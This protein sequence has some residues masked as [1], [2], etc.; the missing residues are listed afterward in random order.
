MTPGKIKLIYFLHG[1]MA[2]D[3][4]ERRREI[5]NKALSREEREENYVEF[6]PKANRKKTELKSIL[7]DLISEMGTVSF[8]PDSK[9]VAVVYNLDELYMKKRKGKAKKSSGKKKGKKESREAFFIRYLEEDL[10]QTGN[11]LI[12]V[13]NENLE[14]NDRINKKSRL[15]KA[16]YK[17]G[18]VEE[19]SSKPLMWDFQD[20]IHNRKLV[21]ALKIADK[22]MAKDRNSGKNSIV[23]ILIREIILMLQVKVS[24]KITP[25]WGGNYAETMETFFPKDLR[26]NYTNLK[27]YPAQKLKRSRKNYTVAELNRALENLLEINKHL[28]P[29]TTDPYV[30][31]IKILIEKFLVEMMSRK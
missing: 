19:F 16:I 12:I 17:L 28:F 20:A 7:P 11:I 4:N 3:L 2:N 23:N 30:P 31:D 24:E 21:D 10:P 18:E 29:L 22:W 9:R 27:S 25:G 13:N 1:N 6:S 8:F 14:E 26:Y 5:V 15:Y